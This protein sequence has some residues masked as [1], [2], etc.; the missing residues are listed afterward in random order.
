MKQRQAILKKIAESEAI[1][2][3]VLTTFEEEHPDMDEEEFEEAFDEYWMSHP[4]YS[5]EIYSDIEEE[6]KEVRRKQQERVYKA[7]DWM[8]SKKVLFRCKVCSFRKQMI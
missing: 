6:Y 3:E 1:F 2:D 5:K 4:S 8:S 7:Q